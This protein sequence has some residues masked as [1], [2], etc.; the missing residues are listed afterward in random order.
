MQR[1]TSNMGVMTRKDFESFSSKVLHDLKLDSQMRWTTAGDIM[2]PPHIYIDERHRGQYP[3]RAKE[4]ILHEVAHID[5]WPKDDGH[6]E[7]FYA[8]YVELL[9]KFMCFQESNK[10]IERIGR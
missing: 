1:L 4:I 10:C 7:I 3:W 2:I 9:M 6:G 8:R 5:T